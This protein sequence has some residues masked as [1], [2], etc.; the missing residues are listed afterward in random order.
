MSGKLKLALPDIDTLLLC[1]IRHSYDTLTIVFTIYLYT[2]KPNQ[3]WTTSL[4][5]NLTFCQ[6]G[7]IVVSH[8]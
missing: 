6:A 4:Y 2:K 7:S 8:A 5:F 1:T 3:P